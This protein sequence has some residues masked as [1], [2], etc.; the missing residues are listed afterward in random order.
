MLFL[1]VFSARDCHPQVICYH[2]W[3]RFTDTQSTGHTKIICKVFGSIKRGEM[4]GMRVLIH[5][6]HEHH[7]GGN[8]SLR[9]SYIWLP[10]YV[11]N[12]TSPNY[13]N[14]LKSV[15]P[16]PQTV[17]TCSKRMG[18][19]AR[20]HQPLHDL[21]FWPPHCVQWWCF[22][23]KLPMPNGLTGLLNQLLPLQISRS[24]ISLCGE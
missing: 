23:L 17:L 19:S 8:R 18:C 15:N 9:H 13:E 6:V 5:V 14:I 10:Y 7:P 20:S 1:F 22:G 12:L 24:R 2:H 16:R 21:W 4:R 11:S 3:H